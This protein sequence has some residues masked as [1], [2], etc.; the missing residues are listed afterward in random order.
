MDRDYIVL[1]DENG[2]PYIAHGL[3]SRVK[4]G[5]RSAG[6][7]AH[8]YILKVG[9]GVK[10][11][12]AY[13]KEEADA[14]LGRGRKAASS[15]SEKVKSGAKKAS[16]S[17]RSGSTKLKDIAREKIGYSARDARDKAHSALTAARA[18]DRAAMELYDINAEKH[19][20]AARDAKIAEINARG[21]RQTQ[22]VVDKQLLDAVRSYETAVRSDKDYRDAEEAARKAE[23]EAKI[24]EINYGGASRTA[25]E[26]DKLAREAMDKYNK[27]DA[28]TLKK[29][30]RALRKGEQNAH[31][32]DYRKAI[33]LNSESAKSALDK[34]SAA[35]KLQSAKENASSA[36]ERASSAKDAYDKAGGDRT[37]ELWY[38]ATELTG[39]DLDAMRT[40]YE[41]DAAA[42]EAKDREEAAKSAMLDATKRWSGK[43]GWG[44]DD[45]YYGDTE[46][47]YD[48]AEA[49]YA[50]TPLAKIDDLKTIGRRAANTIQNYA[51]ETISTI[52]DA[53]DSAKG[54]VSSV[55]DKA[56]E[57]VDRAKESL[58]TASSKVR[59]KAAEAKVSSIEKA[60]DKYRRP[61]DGTFTYDRNTGKSVRASE[62]YDRYMGQANAILGEMKAAAA[63]G[64]IPTQAQIDQVTELYKKAVGK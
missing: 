14:L 36:K 61:S 41:K 10:A 42:K 56:S 7:R 29:V 25:Y 33:E 35:R 20:K 28:S 47:A 60:A 39:K 49:E 5:A 46:R 15:A 3:W 17:I 23:R 26:R 4:S 40:L 2:Q 37:G 57:V 54:T 51:K 43:S 63:R 64:V 6:S 9:E 32:E 21:A 11:R 58:S 48:K 8:K 13:T 34:A 55:R 12:Y 27:D 18:Q 53:G 30:Q 44:T 16:E 22:K 38:K 45:R 24:A 19:E 62:M 59:A 52:K 31:D 1:I 50:K